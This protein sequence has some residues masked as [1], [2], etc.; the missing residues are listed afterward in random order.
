MSLSKKEFDAFLYLALKTKD[1]EV[2]MKIIRKLEEGKRDYYAE[3][4][5]QKNKKTTQSDS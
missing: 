5:T 1:P 3:S 2:R 4:R